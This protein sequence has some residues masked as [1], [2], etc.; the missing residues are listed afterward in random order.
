VKK[1]IKIY[2]IE[3]FGLYVAGEIAGGLTYVNALEGVLVTT[4][5]L[6]VASMLVKPIINILIL[7]LTL[8]TL[9]LL[10]FLSHAVMLYLVDLAL[11]QFSVEGFNFAGL[12]SPYLDLPAVNFPKGI[13]AYVAFSLIISFVT[14]FVNWLRK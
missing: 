7:P 14:G 9:G 13:F 11:V 3:L 12:K 2:A 4:A 10:K 5:G 1:I 6:T 8:A